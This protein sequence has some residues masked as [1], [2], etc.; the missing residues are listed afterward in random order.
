MLLTVA[1]V[2]HAAAPT[3]R[4]RYGLDIPEGWAD[5]LTYS[6][7]SRAE[8]QRLLARMARDAPAAQ[9]TR[10]LVQLPPMS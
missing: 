9:M 5:G 8:C 10:C 7:R 6:I 4:L 2:A 3:V 1:T